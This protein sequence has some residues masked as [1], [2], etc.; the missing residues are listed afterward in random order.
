MVNASSVSVW[1]GQYHTGTTFNTGT[2]IFNFTVYD[3]L[4][5]GNSCFTNTT[6][7]T[8]GNWGEWMIEQ[9]PWSACNDSSKDYFL[10][11]NIAGS[12]QPP[13]R[14]LVVLDFLR[15]DVEVIKE[16][17]LE[18]TDNITAEY[19]IG[20]G[21]LLTGVIG[22]G[23]I[24]SVQG[25]NIYLY[26]GSDS[27]NVVLA[28]NESKLNNTI[29]LRA[30]GL[31]DNS[32]WNETYADTKYLNLSGGNAN[33]NINISPYNFE[34]ANVTLTQKITFGLDE[35]IDNIIDGWLRITGGLNV[36]GDMEIAGN[37]TTEG[38][39][40]ENDSVNHRIY[41]NSTCVIITGDTSTIYIC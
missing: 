27:G 37:I 38:I 32:S 20:D 40:L 2:Y 3:A 39:L 35:M 41:D 7:L 15:Q 12:D 16:G 10:N 34:V 23:D 26:N 9:S 25:D 33:Q 11:I 1:R 28:L 14:R 24:N 13:R 30:S 18:V 21:S 8:T 19:F 29:D 22:G 17:N 6:S 36:T 31:G 5:G 4:T